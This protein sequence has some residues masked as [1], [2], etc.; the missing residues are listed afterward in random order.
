M[1]NK[2]FGLSPGVNP[3]VPW[4]YI[5]KHMNDV[6]PCTFEMQADG[7]KYNIQAKDP[8]ALGEVMKAN[9]ERG[10]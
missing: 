1:K 7:V 5:Y 10:K 4:E 9:K 8:A 6:I 3:L 2:Y